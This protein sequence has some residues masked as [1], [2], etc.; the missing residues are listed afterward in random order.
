MQL[1]PSKVDAKSARAGVGIAT[2][3][4]GVGKPLNDVPRRNTIHIIIMCA[5]NQNIKKYLVWG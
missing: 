5:N 2:A 3:Y 4:A 1:I